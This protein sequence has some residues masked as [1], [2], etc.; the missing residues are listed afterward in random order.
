MHVDDI[1]V[2]GIIKSVYDA[3]MIS[4]CTSSKRN[5]HVIG[6]FIE[7]T[8]LRAQ[9][10]PIDFHFLQFSKTT[11]IQCFT[12]LH[13]D[14]PEIKAYTQL[15]FFIQ[16]FINS[17]DKLFNF[18]P[19]FSISPFKLFEDDFNNF[20]EKIEKIKRNAY[21]FT[22]NDSYFLKG[23]S[24]GFFDEKYYEALKF[25][26]LTIFESINSLIPGIVE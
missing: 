14:Y 1:F 2:S 17:N 22:F 23:Y 6:A 12:L 25:N 11:G 13:A 16:A 21:D 20:N 7:Y 10:L 4:V 9:N 5:K 15:Q 26:S 18:Y 8:A 19:G 24:N 3:N